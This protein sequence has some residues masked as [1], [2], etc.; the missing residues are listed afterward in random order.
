MSSTKGGK[1]ILKK[2]MN[3]AEAAK[4]TEFQF[5]EKTY[6]IKDMATY[7]NLTQRLVALRKEYHESSEDNKK[8]IIV[9]MDIIDKQ[10]KEIEVSA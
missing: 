10:I 3:N 2:E 8:I 1:I 7:K 4:H 6:L 9:Q 5:K